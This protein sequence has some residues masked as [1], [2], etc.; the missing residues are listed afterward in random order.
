MIACS[1][2]I[3]LQHYELFTSKGRLSAVRETVPPGRKRRFLSGKQ[4]AWVEGSAG[5]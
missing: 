3:R 4:L 2:E 1:G 5:G